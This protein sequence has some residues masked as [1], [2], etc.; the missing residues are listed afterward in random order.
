M[1]C[2][3]GH[4]YELKNCTIVQNDQIKGIQQFNKY[5]I[6]KLTDFDLRLQ[7]SHIC[8][9]KIVIKVI[10][11]VERALHC[12]GNPAELAQ[13]LDNLQ[14]MSTEDH[15]GDK[16]NTYLH[17]STLPAIKVQHHPPNTVPIKIEDDQEQV[18]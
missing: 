16:V 17:L 14:E 13:H 4:G 1:D 5:D 9:L 18:K 3:L 8:K 10:H 11:L 2:W 7:D 15:A 6:I 12:L